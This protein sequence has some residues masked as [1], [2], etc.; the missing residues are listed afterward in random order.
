VH[1]DKFGGLV[2]MAIGLGLLLDAED[3]DDDSDLVILCMLGWLGAKP[4]EDPY[5]E[6][7]Q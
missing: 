7:T 2:S 1:A 4:V 6:I 5:I 3:D